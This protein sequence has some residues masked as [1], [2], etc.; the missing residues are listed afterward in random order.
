MFGIKVTHLEVEKIIERLHGWIFDH[1]HERGVARAACPLCEGVRAAIG[2][3]DH[4][5]R[6]PV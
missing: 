2:V 6:E 4:M 5:R 3:I 1:E